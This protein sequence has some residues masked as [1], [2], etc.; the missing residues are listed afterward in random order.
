M[1]FFKNLKLAWST[2]TKMAEETDVGQQFAQTGLGSMLNKLTGKHL[3]GAEREANQFS[4]EQAQIQRDYETEMSN[5][6]YQRQ[7]ADMQ[8]AGVNPA[9]L[10]GSG[11]SGAST[12][13]GSAPSSVAPNSGTSMSE[14]MQ[15]FMMPAQK[16][17]IEAQASNT[18]ALT[19]KARADTEQMKLV[20]KYYPQVTETQI[21]KMLAEIGVDEERVKEIRSNVNLND[22]NA[23]LLKVDKVIKDAEANEASAFFKAR[24]EFEEA[25][26]DKS[27]AEKAELVVRAAME[28]LEK[29][30]MSHT[31]T[32]MGSATVIAIAAALGTLL[33]GF[34]FGEKES[35]FEG[36]NSVADKFKSWTKKYGSKLG[37]WIDKPKRVF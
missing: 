33:S 14:L 8:A 18:D 1:G 9:L 17:L 23:E 16:R 13:S 5:T 37:D 29:N 7:V 24:R 2:F 4:A 11:A 20:N 3:T 10:Y 36:W 28:E 21:D 12:P 31:N 35:I 19:D 27:K 25:Q 26:T 6:A 30:Y 34:S 32:K 15:L 22:L